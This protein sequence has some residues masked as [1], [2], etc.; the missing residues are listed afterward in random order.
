[1][2]VLVALLPAIKTMLAKRKAAAAQEPETVQT[3][4]KV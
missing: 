2:F 3:K 1:V 4:E